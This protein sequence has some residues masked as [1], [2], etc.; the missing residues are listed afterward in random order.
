MSKIH[1]LIIVS[2]EIKIKKRLDRAKYLSLKM[3][4]T[5]IS[6]EKIVK[7]GKEKTNKTN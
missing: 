2:F 7:K 3:C 4:G 1:L 5:I 6:N